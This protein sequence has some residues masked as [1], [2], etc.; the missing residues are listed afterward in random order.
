MTTDIYFERNMKKGK[1]FWRI[2]MIN[3]IFLLLIY[4]VIGGSMNGFEVLKVVV[5]V[6]ESTKELNQGSLMIVLGKHDEVLI[7]DELML[8]EEVDAKLVE[9]VKK[10][11]GMLISVKADAGLAA[12]KLITML[13]KIKKAGGQNLTL[14]TQK[15]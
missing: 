3:V 4:V 2:P 15:P 13:E 14:A 7:N 9:A 1:N 8:P 12:P 6:A 5:P 11:P 10:A